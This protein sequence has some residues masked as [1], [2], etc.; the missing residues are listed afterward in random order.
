MTKTVRARLQSA[1][2]HRNCTAE[3][4]ASQICIGVL[5]RGSVDVTLM[6]F[7]DWWIDRRCESIGGRKKKLKRDPESALPGDS[8]VGP[9][10]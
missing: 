7:H 2:D 3:E 5:T 10:V 9:E 1:A 4:L 6:N 8:P